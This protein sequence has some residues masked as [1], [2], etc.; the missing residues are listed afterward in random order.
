M[1]TRQ[2]CLYIRQKERER[3]KQKESQRGTER[4]SLLNSQPI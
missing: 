3:D 1:L 2:K 4:E